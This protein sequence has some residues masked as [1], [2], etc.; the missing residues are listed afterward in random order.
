MGER[1]LEHDTLIQRRP[2]HGSQAGGVTLSRWVNERPVAGAEL[3][4]AHDVA[5]ITRRPRWALGLLAL[6]GRFPRQAR[7]R[8]RAIGWL[9]RDILEW[10]SGHL[11]LDPNGETQ[12]CPSP[13]SSRACRS[14]RRSR[15]APC[16]LD[17]PRRTPPTH[18]PS[19][20]MESNP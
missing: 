18:C 6:A 5:R 10:M 3:L 13:E 16:R 17:R 11:A 1:T 4:C 12:H 2:R 9:R 20:A 7:F 15:A 14:A 8:G 19:P